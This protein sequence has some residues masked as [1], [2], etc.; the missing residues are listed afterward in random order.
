MPINLSELKNAVVAW[1]PMDDE[2]LGKL[3][4]FKLEVPPTLSGRL[5]VYK[6]PPCA[7]YPSGYW[8][9]LNTEG[10]WNNA[11][12]GCEAWQKV[13]L[14]SIRF[15]AAPTGGDEDP[16]G[17]NQNAVEYCHPRLPLTAISVLNPN[18]YGE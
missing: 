14:C 17:P 16:E 12:P 2:V 5:D 13:L 4:A 11:E 6:I 7:D 3:E 8:F 10:I 18:H 1:G 15:F 9:S